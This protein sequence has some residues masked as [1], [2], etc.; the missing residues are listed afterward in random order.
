MNIGEI[1]SA[2]ALCAASFDDNKDYLLMLKS[3]TNIDVIDDHLEIF[4]TDSNTDNIKLFSDGHIESL[5]Q[6]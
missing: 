2:F 3:V 6:K 5:R 4:F 1:I